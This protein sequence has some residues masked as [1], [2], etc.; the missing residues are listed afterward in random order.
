ML[1]RL[2]ILSGLF[3]ITLWITSVNGQVDWHNRGQW[4]GDPYA[5]YPGNKEIPENCPPGKPW[6]CWEPPFY[7]YDPIRTELPNIGTVVGRSMIFAPYQYINWYLG[8][9]YAKPPVYER[10]FKV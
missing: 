7:P 5:Y 10:R 9:P 8:V 3:I 2:S 1:P 6:P 4:D